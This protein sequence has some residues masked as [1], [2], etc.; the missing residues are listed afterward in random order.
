MYSIKYIYRILL[1]AAPL[2]WSQPLPCL[3]EQ[4]FRCFDGAQ[5]VLQHRHIEAALEIETS[6]AWRSYRGSFIGYPG[7]KRSWKQLWVSCC[8]SVRRCL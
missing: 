1:P 5:D 8:S 3:Q 7:F 2:A 6:C 4:L